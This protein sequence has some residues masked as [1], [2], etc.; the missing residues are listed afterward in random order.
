[1]KA[2]SIRDASLDKEKNLAY[3]L[4]YER[5]KLF[6]IEIEK[7][8]DEWEA[9]LILSS[10]VKRGKYSVGSHWSEVWVEQRI[11]PRD[12]QN[13][14]MILKENHLSEYDPFRLLV[15]ADG[16]CAQ[17]D[18]F[19]VPLRESEYPDT[20]KKRLT[21]TIDDL[22]W[23]DDVLYVVFR[24]ESVRVLRDE[25]VL[26]FIE[27]DALK[28]RVK[29]YGRATMQLRSL[30]GGHEAEMEYDIRIGAAELRKCGKTSAL[31]GEALQLYLQRNVVDTEEAAACLG[32]TRQNVQDLVARGRLAPLKRLKKGF[33]FL[34][35]DLTVL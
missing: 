32:C 6:F 28:R 17:D 3:L 18:C 29:A 23:L 31:R 27:E 34:K 22:F 13:L 15:I 19:I 2:F 25:D 24:D 11:V 26:G 9:P 14:G 5:E 35:K 20:L 7:G 1:M 30:P 4:Y 33:L 16:R 10:F 12:R 8:I 21:E